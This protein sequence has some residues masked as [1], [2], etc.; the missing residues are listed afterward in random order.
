MVEKRFG[1]ESE[2]HARPTRRRADPYSSLD[3]PRSGLRLGARA[4]N[5]HALGV[6]VVDF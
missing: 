3:S 6:A 2:A 5:P 1:G 4:D